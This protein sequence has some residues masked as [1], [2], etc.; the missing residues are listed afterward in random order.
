MNFVQTI[1]MNAQ[2]TVS[3]ET[4]MGRIALSG[5]IYVAHL[6]HSYPILRSMASPKESRELKFVK[7]LLTTFSTLFKLQLP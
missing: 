7:V 4:T 2:Y 5:Y 1:T 3:L 6:K